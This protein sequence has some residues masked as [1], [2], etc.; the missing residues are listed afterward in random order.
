MPEELPEPYDFFVHEENLLGNPLG[1]ATM[2]YPGAGLDWEPINLMM[3][4]TANRTRPLSLLQVIYVDYAPFFTREEV[5]NFVERT[6]RYELGL[7]AYESRELSPSDFRVRG[8]QDFFPPEGAFFRP[9]DQDPEFF[10]MRWN[11][12]EPRISF[13]YLKAEAI[14][15]YQILRKNK[16]IPDLIVLQDH[17]FG[18]GWTDFGGHH[19]LLFQA[20]KLSLPKYLYAWPGYVQ[21]TNAYAG[22]G[23][24]HQFER[25]LFRRRR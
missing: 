18:G 7:E 25:A 23:Q 4:A 13:T 12:R 22:R 14:Y 17:G 6:L 11:L 2:Y 24:M 15:T 21:V 8:L 20:S 3:S 19:S 5:T 10:G 1:V 9:E 16:I